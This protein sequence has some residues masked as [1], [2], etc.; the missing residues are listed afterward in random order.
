MNFAVIAP[1]ANLNTLCYGRPVQMCL[2]PFCND[3]A[4]F[5]WYQAAMQDSIIILDNGVWEGKRMHLKEYVEIAEALN[6]HVVVVPDEI[7]NAKET[8]KLS[9]AFHNVWDWDQFYCRI[10]LMY[11]PQGS[12]PTSRTIQQLQTHLPLDWSHPSLQPCGVR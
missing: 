8:L 4:Y 5:Q 1:T 11:V 10:K 6:P 9:Q 12:L 7:N 2:A 3:L